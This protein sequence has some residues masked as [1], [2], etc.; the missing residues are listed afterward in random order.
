M[1]K[2]QSVRK[3]INR[4]NKLLVLKI[5]YLVLIK[6]MVRKVSNSFYVLLVDYKCSE[7]LPSY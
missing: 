4:I 7:Q 1:R 6:S 5:L 3:R 2:V